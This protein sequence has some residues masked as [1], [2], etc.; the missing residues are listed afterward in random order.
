[1]FDSVVNK[2]KEGGSSA[3][4]DFMSAEVAKKIFF[5]LA[6]MLDDVKDKVNLSHDVLRAQGLHLVALQVNT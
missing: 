4:H 2:L 3:F 6:G 5:E 1:M